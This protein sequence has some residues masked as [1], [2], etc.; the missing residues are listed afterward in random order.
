VDDAI[1][2]TQAVIEQV[3]VVKKGLMQELLTRGLPG[4]HTKYKQTEIGEV[5]EEWEVWLGRIDS[6][7]P[8]VTQVARIQVRTMWSLWNGENFHKTLDLRGFYRWVFRKLV[9]PEVVSCNISS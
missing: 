8:K 4:R 1:E 6:T 2:K 3:Q 9:A 5:P 7:I